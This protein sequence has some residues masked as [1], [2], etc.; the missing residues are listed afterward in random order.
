MPKPPAPVVSLMIS[1]LDLVSLN[2]FLPLDLL[3]R[4]R[5]ECCFDVK[6]QRIPAYNDAIVLVP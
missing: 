1:V 5:K 2:V 6:G 3:F 4:I